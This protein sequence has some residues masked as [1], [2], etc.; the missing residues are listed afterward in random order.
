MTTN[1]IFLGLVLAV[2]SKLCIMCI[3]LLY[4]SDI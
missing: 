1:S 3:I 2:F 4:V